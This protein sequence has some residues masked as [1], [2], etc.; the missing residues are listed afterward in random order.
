MYFILYFSD[1]FYNC[2]I[3]KNMV[4]TFNKYENLIHFS[5]PTFCLKRIEQKEI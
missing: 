2:K 5:H 1:L 3:A 4:G